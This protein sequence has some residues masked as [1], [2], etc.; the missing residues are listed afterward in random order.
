MT[1]IVIAM[2]LTMVIV[3]ARSLSFWSASRVAAARHAPKTA[4][5]VARA[6][7]HLNGE[8]QPPARFVRFI[9]HTLSR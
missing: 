5:R 3:S 4:G 7:R 6:A 9:E 1:S 8:G 2:A